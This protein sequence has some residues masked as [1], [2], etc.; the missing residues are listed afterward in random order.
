MAT[1]LNYNLALNTQQGVKN[2]T[3]LY[4]Y[5]QSVFNK[6]FNVK[7]GSKGSSLPL[8]KIGSDFKQ[9]GGAIDAATD[10]VVAFTATT[11]LIYAMGRGLQRL[12]S[13]AIAVEAA[14]TSIQ[15]IL[16]ATNS[17]LSK[18]TDSIF[19]LAN[20]TGVG[21]FDAAKAAEEFARQGLSLEKTLAATQAA[22]GIFRVSGGDITKIIEGLTSSVNSFAAEGIGFQEVADK[23]AALDAKF[24]TSATGLIEGLKRVG[25]TAQDAGISFDEL[26]AIIASVRQVSGRT[27]AVIGNGLKTI[28][29]NL[30]NAGIQE[31][32]EAIGVA[33]R[34]AGGEFRP[35]IDVIRDLSTA[36]EGLTDAQRAELSTKIAGKFQINTF[37][38]LLQAT[39]QG[40][41]FETGLETARGADGDI[42]K[43]IELL[44]ETTQTALQQFQNNITRLGAT[45][46]DSV[47]KEFVDKVLH[48][49]DVAIT[50][51]ADLFTKGNPIGA[52]LSSGLA[53]ALTGPGFLLIGITVAKLGKRIVQG[54]SEGLKSITNLNGLAQQQLSIQQQL[55]GVLQQGNNILQQ[56][57]RQN[58]GISV[59]EYRKRQREAIGARNTAAFLDSPNKFFG[60]DRNVRDQAS[61][62]GISTNSPAF[63]QK[64]KE[65]RESRSNKAIAA[66]FGVSFLGGAA[67]SIMPE[68]Q[69]RT[70]VEAGTTALGTA[71]VGASFGPLGAAVGAVI[72]GFSFLTS[73]TDKLYN[74]LEEVNSSVRNSIAENEKQ[75]AAGQEYITALE[76]LKQVTESGTTQQKITAAGNVS[77][78]GSRLKGSNRELLT[79]RTEE[80]RLNILERGQRDV[81]SSNS[82]QLAVAAAEKLF[83]KAF[84]NLN[85]RANDLLGDRAP[86]LQRGGIDNAKDLSSSIVDTIDLTKVNLEELNKRLLEFDADPKALQNY[87][88]SLVTDPGAE[89]AIQ[90]VSNAFRDGES[91]ILSRIG[92][93]LALRKSSEQLA[94]SQQSL[95]Q[96]TAALDKSF[97]D[98]F[99]AAAKE[100]S[101]R[102]T[103]TLAGLERQVGLTGFQGAD[104][105]GS[106]AV[107]FGESLEKLELETAAVASKFQALSEYTPKVL[108]A[109]TEGTQGVED[110]QSAL[111]V[112]SEFLKGSI[113]S[114]DLQPE[115]EKLLGADKAAAVFQQLEVT[116]TELKES[117]ENIDSG[118]KNQLQRSVDKASAARA[119]LKLEKLNKLFGDIT[120][121]PTDVV[122]T[123]VAG[124]DARRNITELSDPQ[125]T[126]K[127][128]A[129]LRGFR[130]ERELGLLSEEE[131]K[132]RSDELGLIIENLLE[133]TRQ[134]VGLPQLKGFLDNEKNLTA[135]T[136]KSIEQA[137][138]AGNFDKINQLLG[139]D[140][141]GPVQE[142]PLMA[143][144]GQERNKFN[145]IP[146]ARDARLAA[147]TGLSEEAQIKEQIIN[148]NT[149]LEN[150]KANT[151]IQAKNLT[152]G[153]L[154]EDVLLKRFKE[155]SEQDRL[156]KEINDLSFEKTNA[157]RSLGANVTNRATVDSSL[158][159]L[160][161][162]NPDD[163]RLDI[164]AAR[165]SNQNIP[166]TVFSDEAEFIRDAL[167]DPNLDT[168]TGINKKLI[169]K[170]GIQR[171]GEI[172]GTGVLDPVRPSGSRDSAEQLRKIQILETQ[173]REKELQ[174][175]KSEKKAADVVKPEKDEISK[176]IDNLTS[177]ISNGINA[178]VSNS[179]AATVEISGT[180]VP[181]YTSPEFSAF[182]SA[183][184]RDAYI[185][186]AKQNGQNPTIIPT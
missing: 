123:I 113:S 158:N 88:K 178:N 36:F 30:Q 102:N 5:G 78:L 98:L 116:S 179:V 111:K 122:K 72:G 41:F 95:I 157:Q 141:N 54:V 3:A 149:L 134:N 131:I 124:Q 109:I 150:I 34:D 51:L 39:R 74:N 140:R 45:L 114:L 76:K 70:I 177:A 52:A 168:G 185:E 48:Y 153:S 155:Q 99:T 101:R 163:A 68:S 67:A 11:S 161:P 166:K 106:Q 142:T 35:V 63:A 44:N 94:K 154:T 21:F 97:R 138:A 129:A 14:I 145:S 126:Q 58:S 148:S 53:G 57:S 135:E 112:V 96:H 147:E 71:L 143:F 173:L 66:G 162:R 180:V 4:N 121:D 170:F 104:L 105:Q 151:E 130:A 8:G 171:G 86:L 186:F 38:S 176:S 65:G 115:L 118:L 103:Q 152:T 22:L 60:S 146:E 165:A 26:G 181:D 139:L 23:L 156:R 91:A 133:A 108:Q 92:P 83:T 87:I 6:G 32:I 47:G 119:G 43:R 182:L 160:L 61:R 15:S 120:Q 107:K 20:K 55:N 10:R 27:E 84:E 89:Q 56:R 16:N 77:R 184:M 79:A 159:A 85:D 2:I 183:K 13:D 81:N 40:G 59:A 82:G 64:Q 164:S 29:T 93:E 37:K 80:E 62:F 31:R 49:G 90:R 132:K 50:G 136:K 117:F 7:I 25:A 12:V 19:D 110:R 9:F 69:A 175:K 137:F 172:I 18:F 127:R 33:V 144:L 42:A 174:L 28:V 128:I 169:E 24:A 73:V 125:G 167:K 46:G 1:N 75:V 100:A 17:D